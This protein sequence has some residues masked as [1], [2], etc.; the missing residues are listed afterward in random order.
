MHALQSCSG[1]ISN[2]VIRQAFLYALCLDMQGFS[3]TP[4][5]SANEIYLA[6]SPCIVL[7]VHLTILVII[8]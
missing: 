2:Y 6:K 4:L 5:I 7:N 8:F 1:L 3:C